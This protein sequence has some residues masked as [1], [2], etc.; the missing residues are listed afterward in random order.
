[1]V[2]ATTAIENLILC[3]V[4]KIKTRKAMTKIKDEK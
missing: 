4:K 3:V 2:A 1:M